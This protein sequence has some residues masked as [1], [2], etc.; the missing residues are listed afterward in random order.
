MRQKAG[1]SPQT[2]KKKVSY[3]RENLKGGLTFMQGFL[4]A[5]S[6]IFYKAAKGIGTRRPYVAGAFVLFC[7]AVFVF[8]FQNCSVPPI[9]DTDAKALEEAAKVDFA[10]DASIDQ[11]T[12]MSCALAMPGTFDRGAYYSFRIG[13]YRDQAGLR[14]NDSFRLAYGNRPADRQSSILASSPANTGTAVQLGVRQLNNFQGLYTADGNPKNGQDYVNIFET[15]GTLD[16]SDLLVRISPTSRLRY[17]RNGSVFGARFEGDL[18]FTQNPTLSGSI[19]TILNN[20]GF[21]GLTYSYSQKGSGGNTGMSDTYARAP[22]Y[23]YEDTGSDPARQVYGRGFYLRFTQPMNGNTPAHQ[24]FPNVILKSVTEMNLLSQ[25]GGTGLGTWTCPDTLRLK[26]VRAEDA[27]APGGTACSMAP[28]P[29]VLTP[30][31]VIARNQLRVEDWYIDMTNKCIVPKKDPGTC[32]GSGAGVTVQYN[33][34]QDCQEGVSPSC[35][36]FASICYR[37]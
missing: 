19:R 11:I 35:V 4:K 34:T 31:L 14:L 23:L 16:L 10:Y 6:A 29:A 15:L 28:D 22:G 1:G 36:S 12:Y 27:G 26:I 18:N 17:L 32:Y 5:V 2:N 21:L 9:V 13:A 7:S 3:T 8:V 37:Q 33:I 24:N 20:D 30:D 25:T